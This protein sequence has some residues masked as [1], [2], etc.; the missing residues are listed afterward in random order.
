MGITQESAQYEDGKFNTDE[1]EMKNEII[2]NFKRCRNFYEDWEKEAKHDYRFALGDQWTS[3]EIEELKKQGRPAMTFNRIRPIINIVSGYQ[4]DNSARIKVNPE[5]G[6]DKVFSDVMDRLVKAIDKWSHLSFKSGY[7]FDD[8]LYCGKGWIEAIMS[9]SNDPIRGTLEFKQRTP[10]QILHDPDFREYDLNDGCGYLIKVVRLTKAQ[11]K[12]LYP[13]KKKVISGFVKDN[14]DDVENGAGLLDDRDMDPQDDNYGND[15]P[16]SYQKTSAGN[17][18]DT[19]GGDGKFTLKEYWRHKYVT[20]YFVVDSESSEPR[21]FDTEEQAQAFSDG[22]GGGNIIG[23]TV[24]EM[25]VRAYACGFILQ[26][27]K[28]PFE[29][30]YSGYPFFRFLSDWAPNAEEEKWRVQGVTRPLK[31]PQKEK[32]KAKSQYL[33]T[34]NTQANSGWIGDD[35]ALTDEGWWQLEQMGSKP[36]IVVKK[37]PGKE[38][39]EIQPKALNQSQ[40]VRE[41]QADGEFKQISN[42]NPD[43]MGLQSDSSSGKAMSIRIKQAVLALARL[44]FNY[45]YSKEIMGLFILQMV[46]MLFDV[47]KAKRVIGMDFIKKAVD[48]EKYPNGLSDGV[49]EGF[50]KMVKDNK[51]DVLVTEADSNSTMRFETFQELSELLKAGAPIPIELLID[52]M[53]LPNSKEIKD[54]IAQQ[55]QQMA[56][57]EAAK[58]K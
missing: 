53:D 28:S 17:D 43:L 10:Y 55:R 49:L 48:P 16:F 21:K 42:I 46:P 52:Y 13:H 29:P 7:W 35:D 24:P 32:N 12:S 37:K 30:F 27:E 44:F 2:R 22:Q 45:R 41:E 39:R 36:G 3:E 25:W 54:Q 20:K 57:A 34:I 40:I 11:L 51:Y 4:R 15:R 33:H 18:D 5:G 50:L 47:K 58:G 23:R 14:D 31:D 6:E 1:E 38:L 8:G 19:H 26:D 56:E 9:Y